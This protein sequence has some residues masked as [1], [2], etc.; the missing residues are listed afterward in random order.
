MDRCV[1]VLNRAL[2]ALQ[3]LEANADLGVCTPTRCYADDAFGMVAPPPPAAHDVVLLLA[4]AAVS[5]LT[6]RT[7]LRAGKA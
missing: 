7:V 6:L 4:A 3:V 5:A 2:T 1:C